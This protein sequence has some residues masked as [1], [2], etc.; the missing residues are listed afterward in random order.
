M[1]LLAFHFHLA[2]AIPRFCVAEESGHGFS[3]RKRARRID[4]SAVGVG[5]E[6]LAG[7]D[8]YGDAIGTQLVIN[9]RCVPV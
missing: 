6:R 8:L 1:A 5:A 9:T 2:Q 7:L 4:A 3:T